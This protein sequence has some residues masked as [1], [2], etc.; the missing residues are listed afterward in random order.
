MYKVLVERPR[1]AHFQASN[2]I[3][4]LKRARNAYRRAKHFVLDDHGEVC[5]LYCATALPMRSRQL[6]NNLKMFSENLNPLWRFLRS[7]AGRPWNDVYA[8]IRAQIHP[9]AAV[10]QH[11]LQHIAWDVCS[12]TRRGTDGRVWNWAEIHGHCDRKGSFYVEPET[13]VLRVG[14]K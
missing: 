7:R 12:K 14:S 8:E 4:G 10:Q 5:D 3:R 11:V 1:V 9:N 6:R 13:G 2:S